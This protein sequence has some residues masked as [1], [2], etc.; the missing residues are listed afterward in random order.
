M[1]HSRKRLLRVDAVMAAA[2]ERGID[3]L[4]VMA[5]GSY[6]RLGLKAVRDACHGANTLSN[7]RA[8]MRR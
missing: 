2:R 7:A 8:I 5:E 6:T 4:S 3:A 1:V